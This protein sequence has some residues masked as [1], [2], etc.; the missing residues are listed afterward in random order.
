[1]RTTTRHRILIVISAALVVVVL[2]GCG[3]R[4]DLAGPDGPSP[5]S[6]TV[7]ATS[8]PGQASQPAPASPDP[9]SSPGAEA[10]PSTAPTDTP[11]PSPDLASI[12]ALL[13]GIDTDLGDD[14]AA[15]ANEGN[16]Q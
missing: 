1:M 15:A 3:R 4:V 9:T 7:G 8:L 5:S 10:S 12:E 13:S 16:P 6:V 14:A 2:A 11:I